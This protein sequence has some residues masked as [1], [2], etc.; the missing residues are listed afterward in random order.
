MYENICALANINRM[1]TTSYDKLTHIFVIETLIGVMDF[2]GVYGKRGEQPF[3]TKESGVTMR[4]PRRKHKH[5]RKRERKRKAYVFGTHYYNR[6]KK[7]HHPEDEERKTEEE[8]SL[9]DIGRSIWVKHV[10]EG[11]ILWLKGTVIDRY[12][13]WHGCYWVVEIRYSDKTI[14]HLD[15]VGEFV[16]TN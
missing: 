2:S 5:K 15:N 4:P 11:S 14:I 8:H 6:G 9:P 12:W 13:T 1:T 3:F 16:Y 10:I 7:K